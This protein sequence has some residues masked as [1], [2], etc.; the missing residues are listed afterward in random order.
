MTHG[1]YSPTRI[2]AK[3]RA[4]RRRLLRNIGLAA[5][6]LDGMARGSTVR[7]RQRATRNLLETAGF[8]LVMPPLQQSGTSS[9][10][11]KGNTTGPDTKVSLQRCAPYVLDAP[12]VVQFAWTE[13]V[14]TVRERRSSLRSAR[15]SSECF[16]N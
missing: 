14:R 13:L 4:H 15:T 2:R 16:R 10:Q 8:L 5:R 12:P 7:V 11:R 3:A 9:G 6:D 1:A